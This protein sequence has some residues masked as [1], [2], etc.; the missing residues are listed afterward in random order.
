MISFRLGVEDLADTR[1]AISPLRE[2]MG[3][4]RALRAPALYPLHV[5]WRAAVL[6]A[7]DPADARLLAALVGDTL[8][9]PDFL[10]PRPA[11][12][13]PTLDEQLAVVRA[14]PPPTVRRDL[15]AAHAPRPLPGALR[16]ADA[17][18]DAPVAELL[19]ELCALLRR[20]WQAALLPHWPRMR[21]VLE[22]DVTHRARHLAAGGARSLF[23]GLHRNLRW[24]D[25]VL[26]IDRMR[27]HHHVDASGR[28]L[29]LV[30]SVFAHQPAPPVGAGEP[31]MLAYPSRGTATLW[32]PEPEPGAPALAALL[33]AP[34]STLLRLLAEPLPTVELARLLGVTPSAVSQHLR[35]L[36]ASGLVTRARDGR[37]VLYRRSA[38]GDRLAAPDP[39]RAAGGLRE[40]R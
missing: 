19:E 1:F 5:R 37:R 13:A 23:S 20:Y 25:G 11:S 33:G 26:H 14:T 16:A 31:P 17:P 38:L 8:A 2:V 36:Y 3:S 6:A 39:A 15:R 30:P 22:A 40:G 9:L 32:E 28:G 29:R 24:D 4:L 18:G 10:T 34:R 27:G 21:L 7:L 35:V 12:F